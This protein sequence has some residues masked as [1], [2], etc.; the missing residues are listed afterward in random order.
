MGGREPTKLL[1]RTLSPFAAGVHASAAA[2]ATARQQP[3]IEGD[4]ELNDTRGKS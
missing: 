1:F 4:F 2:H 3:V